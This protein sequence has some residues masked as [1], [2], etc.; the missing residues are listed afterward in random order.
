M[1]WWWPFSFGESTRSFNLANDHWKAAKAAI[2]RGDETECTR[3]CTQTV[4]ASQHTVHK[5]PKNGDAYLLLTEALVQLAIRA[6]SPE[7]GVSILEQAFSVWHSWKTAEP[8]WTKNRRH[9]EGLRLRLAK[10]QQ[11][12]NKFDPEDPERFGLVAFA[13]I[14][15]TFLELESISHITS[16][17]SSGTS[18]NSR[19][20][21]RHEGSEEPLEASHPPLPEG[22][23]ASELAQSL[24]NGVLGISVRSM[25]KTDQLMRSNEPSDSDEDF[26][27]RTLR[28]WSTWWSEFISEFGLATV[29]WYVGYVAR[30]SMEKE[31]KRQF[32]DEVVEGIV[33]NVLQLTVEEKVKDI[34]N[35]PATM[36]GSESLTKEQLESL[37][38]WTSNIA[39]S[40]RSVA[41]KTT[42]LCQE[43]MR[44]TIWDATES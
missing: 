35:T 40:L 41:T 5:D 15:R 2:A 26:S 25:E 28:V 14:G 12:L 29:G 44:S 32:W 30:T 21:S 38:Q 11:V 6:D 4:I 42:D 31:E 24:F 1:P 10:A 19:P 13:E 16:L 37:N 7:N 27:E 8:I 18:R 9:A 17:Y 23:S 20:E 33:E 43:T 39:T 36:A 3:L 22:A 34:S